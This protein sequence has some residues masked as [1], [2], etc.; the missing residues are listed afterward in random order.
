[1]N[2]ENAAVGP[3]VAIGAPVQKISVAP[4]GSRAYVV[5]DNSTKIRIVSLQSGAALGEI[6]PGSD[7]SAIAI[8]PTDPLMVAVMTAGGGLALYRDGVKLP[9]PSWVDTIGG[10]IVFNASVERWETP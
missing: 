3:R 1:M 5:T 9:S 8:S 10:P 2:P 6:V 4:D 7:I